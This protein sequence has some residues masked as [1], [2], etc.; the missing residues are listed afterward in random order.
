MTD[1]GRQTPGDNSGSSPRGEGFAPAGGQSREPAALG[2]DTRQ[3]RR[4]HGYLVG[5]GQLPEA[6]LQV[7]EVLLPLQDESGRQAGAGLSGQSAG[8]QD[9]PAERGHQPRV[10]ATTFR[11]CVR[12]KGQDPTPAPAG[13]AGPFLWVSAATGVTGFGAGSYFFTVIG[14]S[15]VGGNQ[16]PQELTARRDG[17]SCRRRRP[18]A[19]CLPPWS[20][21]GRS[22]GGAW[23]KGRGNKDHGELWKAALP[24][25]NTVVVPPPK[26]PH[27]LPARPGSLL[28]CPGGL[29]GSRPLPVTGGTVSSPPP[30][31]PKRLKAAR[32]HPPAE[33]L[34]G[35]CRGALRPGLGGGSSTGRRGFSNAAV[36]KTEFGSSR[37]PPGKRPWPPSSR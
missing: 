28:P 37:G 21:A 29:S 18:P 36:L 12:E 19:R 26:P 33:R 22:V 14:V 30:G 32:S 23:G 8:S 9:S 20:A 17:S 16:L 24:F 15:A 6:S 3:H 31:R 4:H 35:S 25:P 5:F 13:A 1:R 7:M 10:D 2:Q 34:S 27:Q 11:A